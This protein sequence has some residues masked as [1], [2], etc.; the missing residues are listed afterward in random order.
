MYLYLSAFILK[1]FYRVYSKS[2]T[3][4][5]E[6]FLL[7][8]QNIKTFQYILQKK[9]QSKVMWKSFGK[10]IN[11]RYVVPFYSSSS[12]FFTRLIRSSLRTKEN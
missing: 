2:E 12:I 8:V 11:L 6:L 3:V 5:F 10:A 4:G 1:T 7:P 9:G